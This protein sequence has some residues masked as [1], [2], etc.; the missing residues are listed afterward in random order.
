M[1]SAGG[2]GEIKV[3]RELQ[4]SKQ[5]SGLTNHA[6]TGQE[7]RNLQR[8]ILF[9]NGI[10]PLWSTLCCWPLCSNLLCVPGQCPQCIPPPF[11]H[12]EHP[13]LT[14]VFP[15]HRLCL[16][17]IPQAGFGDPE[18]EH[19]LL[20]CE[21]LHFPGHALPWGPLSHQDPDSPGPGLQ[22]HT[23]TRVCHPPGLPAPGSL[24]DC[25]QQRPDLE[26]GKCPLRQEGAAAAGK[27]LGQCQEAV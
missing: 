14:G 3:R 12:K 25:S 15:Q 24:T 6:R 2:R 13:C 9:Q 27:F 21:C 20:P 8:H 18:S 5:V 7:K 11:L 17:P 23:H 22:P 19:L 4:P 10:L 26:D 16:P 1:R